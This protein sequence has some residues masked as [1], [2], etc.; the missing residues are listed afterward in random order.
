[1]NSIWQSLAWKEW[2]EHKWKLV[3]ITAVLSGVA[4]IVL[5]TTERFDSL[6]LA[7]GFATVCIPPLALFIGAS[8][9]AGERSHGTL[10]F[11]QSLPVPLWRVAV[12]KATAGLASLSIAIL[13]A[14]AFMYAWISIGSILGH[15]GRA[16][17][18][19][20][21]ASGVTGVWYVDA[22]LFVAPFAAS[23][24]AWAAG[25]GVN[26]KDEVSAAAAALVC[27]AVWMGV[28]TAYY[29]IILEILFSGDEK[30]VVGLRLFGIGLSTVPGGAQYA[31][32]IARRDPVSL[33]LFI[34]TAIVSFVAFLS[35]YILRFGTDSAVSN[36]QPRSAARSSSRMEWLSPPGRNAVTA[37]A[38][39]QIRETSPAA[40][41]G[42]A[43]SV[44]ISACIVVSGAMI[45]SKPLTVSITEIYPNMAITLG[46]FVALVAGVGVAITDTK[47]KQ[48]DFW[49]SRPIQA[50]LWFWTKY[51]VA[52]GVVLA[53]IYLPIGILVA[54][55]LPVFAYL[56][57]DSY[58]IP[59]M[60]IAVFSAAIASASFIRHAVY[61]AILSIGVVYLTMIG[62]LSILVAATFLKTGIAQ[63][64]GVWRSACGSDCHRPGHLLGARYVR[65][66]AG[67]AV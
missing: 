15:T 18:R 6:Q 27:L 19:E 61:S 10:P 48:N 43:A 2:H 54:T 28:L 11:L 3:S 13:F 65:G 37:T 26:R 42:L 20:M 14:I 23:V 47:Q 21:Q 64:V 8:A 4:A 30:N 51:V 39:K 55:G 36:T 59:V 66:L 49:R 52:L 12:V 32:G 34:E 63:S 1:M 7:I 16:I 40:F 24:F 46:C 45:H 22:F 25:T 38:W 60:H 44:A 29:V 9:A 41:A 33:V 31:S 62:W 56:T 67:D 17:T 5:I 58:L 53:S 50:D 57:P 35:L